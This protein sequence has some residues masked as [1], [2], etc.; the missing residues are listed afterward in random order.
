V[1]IPYAEIAKAKARASGLALQL[2]AA[3]HG[4]KTPADLAD[5]Q[6]RRARLNFLRSSL[7][8]PQQAVQTFERIIAGDEL[9]PVNYLEIGALAAR[10]V[11]RI[12]IADAGGRLRGWATGFMIAPRVLITNNHVL[13]DEAT[14][15]TSSIQ[16]DYELDV[17]GAD[18]PV[19]EFGLDPAALFHTTQ[20][21]DFAVCA[22]AP[23]AADGAPLGAYGFLPL[24]ASVGKVMDGEWLSITQHPNGERKQVCV[25]ENHLL[26]RTDEVLWYSTD[27]LGG[28]SG[29]PVFNN[30]WQVVALHHCGVPDE[31]NG[32]PQTVDGR[33][34]DPARDPE[35]AIKWIA[36]EGIRVS[37]I[38]D[39]LKTDLP[40][41]PLL[42]EVF[43]MT[44]AR[45]RAV[46]ES[47]QAAL[48]GPS[49]PV[50]ASPPPPAVAPAPAAPS[51]V[52]RSPFEMSR[53]VTITLDIADDGQVS[54]RG[55]APAARE[56]LALE[57][58]A[59]APPKPRP[60]EY[61]VPFDAD[62]SS[63]KGYDPG[64]LGQGVTVDLPKLGPDL[65]EAAARLLGS[66]DYVLK[67]D[68][69]SVV[70]HAARRLALY[71]AASV[72][73][74][75]RF[76]LSRTRDVWRFDPRISRKAQLGDFYY[77]GNKF[78]R[79]HLTRR[80]DMETGADPK[81]AIAR[82]D[83]TC[84]F[85]NCTPQHMAFNRSKELWQGLERHIL[86]DSIE[87]SVFGAQVF[88]GP[89]LDEGDP[90]W[91][92]YPDIQ[93]PLQFWKIAVALTSADEL[94]AAAFILDQADVVAKYGI[95]EAVEVPF[96]AFKTFQV[97]VAEVERLTG[98]TFG[99]AQ[100]G[101]KG[102]LRDADPLKGR[103]ARPGR[104]PL[105]AT[106]AAMAAGYPEG[107]LLLDDP[108]A[109]VRP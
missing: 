29:S 79:G 97:T 13:P 65:E 35:T 89:V 91:K 45:A 56:S 83:D 93:Y 8:D 36:N 40:G 38:V 70:M 66:Q 1:I 49:R 92:T 48:R 37:R 104:S 96:D 72:D 17:F 69:Y 15:R 108:A 109:I 88:T 43:D 90:V 95:E 98:L 26:T 33:D 59:A 54:V 18:M 78:D 19:V 55:A 77:D 61:D 100:N 24:M 44:P 14:A 53:S 3:D 28:S 5:A 107:Y 71:S 50:P 64:F 105:R 103:A 82:A 102:F 39:R 60:A 68:G 2:R 62:Y 27:T 42:A 73:G 63:R 99:Y 12:R 81:A 46:V 101:K 75:H 84:H 22:V 76:N 94:F 52:A 31:K 34:Y 87:A 85:T 41:H 25:R 20:D 58:G 32:V 74:A 86:E 16:F 67:Y 9:Q 7:G 4:D 106:E 57:R 21:L 51:P 6:D 23:A 47:L 10:P 30:D 80:E 11:G